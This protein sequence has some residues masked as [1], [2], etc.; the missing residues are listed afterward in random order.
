MKK[1]ILLENILD[2][3]N[4]SWPRSK[5][6]NQNTLDSINL[7]YKGQEVILNAFRSG[8]LPIKTRGK[9]LKR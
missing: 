5:K 2:F 1:V 9:G 6:E 7:L 8:I 4:K 3:S